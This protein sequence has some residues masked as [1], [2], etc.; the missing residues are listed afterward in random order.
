M[1]DGEKK[2]PLSRDL[3]RNARSASVSACRRVGELACL[4]PGLGIIEQPVE[5]IITRSC[6]TRLE[7]LEAPLLLRGKGGKGEWWG[8]EGAEGGAMR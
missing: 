8:R 5:R 6:V 7:A 1:P 2:S 3:E 4:S